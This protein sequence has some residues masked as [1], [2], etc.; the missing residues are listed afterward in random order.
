MSG[1]PLGAGHNVMAAIAA[2]TDAS[3][4]PAARRSRATLSEGEREGEREGEYDDEDER[5]D[6]DEDE[7][8]AGLFRA[9]R[10]GSPPTW[11]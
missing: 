1:F 7:R 6:D 9:I 4:R 11:S 3:A 2:L 8:G 10:E 5:E